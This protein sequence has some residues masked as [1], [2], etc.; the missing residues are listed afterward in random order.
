MLL[1]YETV[2]V[3]EKCVLVPYRPEHVI[4]YHSWMQDPALLEAT[5][6]EPLSLEQEYEMQRTWRDDEAK[7]TFIVLARDLVPNECCSE[8]LQKHSSEEFI[9]KSLSAMVGDVNMFLSE[10]EDETDDGQIDD[11][12][13]TAHAA[14]SSDRIKESYRQAELDIMIAFVASFVKSIKTIPLRS[15]YFNPNWDSGSVRTPNAFG[16]W[17]WNSSR[18]RQSSLAR[19]SSAKGLDRCKQ[20][21]VLPNEAIHDHHTGNGA[22]ERKGSIQQ[23]RSVDAFS[24]RANAIVLYKFFIITACLEYQVIIVQV[25]YNV[26]SLFSAKRTNASRSMIR[27]STERGHI[28][29]LHTIYGTDDR[30]HRPGS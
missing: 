23:S 6:S 10:D 3:G 19:R 22:R 25:C 8:L 4:Q 11:E 18:N 27:V 2:I 26:S 24:K 30:P 16:K 5:A 15:N 13:I 17:N 1:N 28:L 21:T 29:K 20:S 12:H 9:Q 7:C 14:S